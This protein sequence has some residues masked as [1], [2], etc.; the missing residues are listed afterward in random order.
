VRVARDEL[1]R[2]RELTR[3]IDALQRKLAVLV[4]NRAP[5]LLAS[6]AAAC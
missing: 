2:I 1:R 4:A 6:R 5:Q 3:S